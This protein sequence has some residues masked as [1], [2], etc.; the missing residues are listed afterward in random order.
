MSSFTNV[1]YHCIKANNQGIKCLQYGQYEQ[2]ASS[3]SEALFLS[4][5]LI[6]TMRSHYGGD[7]ELKCGESQ[8]HQVRPH[9]NFVSMP[10]HDQVMNQKSFVVTTPLQINEDYGTLSIVN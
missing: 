2:A 6:N 8:E 3:F 1:E 7:Q 5:H 10:Q 4:K 9:C